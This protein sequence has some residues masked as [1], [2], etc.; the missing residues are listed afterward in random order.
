MNLL[1]VL[2]D[3]LDDL[4]ARDVLTL[5]V[6]EISSFTDT[7]LIASG[8]SR[9]QVSSLA[10]HAIERA[11]AAGFEI[12]GKEGIEGGE[13]AVIDLGEVVVHV[14]QPEIREYYQLERL[15]DVDALDEAQ[16]GS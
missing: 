9:R 16:T 3:A 12:L 5:N 14:M 1:E 11:K 2:I 7:L 4:K 6:S 8:G 15:W 13:W 10:E